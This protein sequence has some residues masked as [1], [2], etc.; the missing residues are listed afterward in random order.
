M[1]PKHKARRASLYVL[2]IIL[3]G[4]LTIGI[5]NVSKAFGPRQIEAGAI[6]F[7]LP[8]GTSISIGKAVNPFQGLKPNAIQEFGR[9][10]EL[11]RVGKWSEAAE[12][13]GSIALQAPDLEA[14]L[15]KKTR[16]LLAAPDLTADTRG[17]IEGLLAQLD[18][19]FSES[20]TVLMLHGILAQRLSQSTVAL[21]FLE[22]A[23]QKLPGDPEVHWL[24]GNVLLQGGQPL[25]AATEARTAISLSQ[26]SDSR[27]YSL[28][29]QS[30][31]DDGQ[32]DS[33]ANVLEYGLTR[34]PGATDLMVLNGRLLEYRG[35]FDQADQS[36][37]R[38]LTLE[39]ANLSAI[40][41]LR[42]LGEKSPPGQ[43]GKGIITPR[44][45]AQLA[46]DILEPLVTQYPENLPLREALGQ[47]Y[48][49][50]RQFDLARLQF[51]SIQEKDSEY[52]D[53]QL[54]I[55]EAKSVN[56][57]PAMQLQLSENLKRGVDSLRT[58]KSSE[59]SFSE[60]LGHYLLPWGSTQKEFFA[61]YAQTTFK[62]L[63][64]LTWQED[65]WEGPVDTRTTV[66]FRKDQGLTAIHVTVRDTSIHEGRRNV[67]YDIYGRLLGMNSRISGN[68]VST[69]DT[70]CDS[71][72][73]QGAVWE[74]KDNFEIMVQFSNR[75][76]EVR[77]LRLDP[78]QFE[79]MPRLCGHMPQIQK[80]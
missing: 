59:R 16:A 27:F 10:D 17:E 68:G 44:D 49:K 35:N 78:R 58:I 28:L 37:R 12:V 9:A 46:I 60:R 13:Y 56:R 51:E 39:P 19:K 55:Q 2:S 7:G 66:I 25:G 72:N 47:S 22:Q 80:Y 15:T 21:E 67:V 63:D 57:E 1:F 52:P 75:R 62:K 54:R 6:P 50:S 31:H 30:Y 34:F 5:Y 53:I 71:L 8:P 23:A 43:G 3:G 65:G 4:L 76:S 38:V 14:P 26:G 79:T 24:L 40:E 18:R 77:L 11:L 32:L 74:A 70:Q 33:C 73:F 69:G 20:G 48:L 64:D 29:A 36:Y 42:T 45:K 41:A 61:R